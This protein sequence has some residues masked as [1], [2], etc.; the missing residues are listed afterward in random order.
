MT[1]RDSYFS[2]PSHFAQFH[3]L[4]PLIFQELH[5]NSATEWDVAGE[6]P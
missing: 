5:I 2:Q 3:T 4:R 6:V 1:S